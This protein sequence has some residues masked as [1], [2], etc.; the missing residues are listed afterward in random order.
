MA[1][2]GD[3]LK[4]LEQAVAKATYGGTAEEAMKQWEEAMKKWEEEQKPPDA[5]A[6]G[7]QNPE[8]HKGKKE[9]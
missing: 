9:K 5:G 3:R 6:K 8:Q 1:N 7:P 4:F 2:E